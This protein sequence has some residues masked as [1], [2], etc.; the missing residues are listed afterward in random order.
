VQDVGCGVQGV[1][2]RVQGAG[3]QGAGFSVLG[4]VVHISRLMG[5]GRAVSASFQG[6][7]GILVDPSPGPLMS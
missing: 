5:A 6:A 1:G 3:C 2:C 4:S 7:S